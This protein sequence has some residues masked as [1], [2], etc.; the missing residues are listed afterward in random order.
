MLAL[1]IHLLFLVSMYGLPEIT[2]SA[3]LSLFLKKNTAIKI[4]LILKSINP[5]NILE[6]GNSDCKKKIGTKEEMENEVASI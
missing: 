5:F 2:T 4:R 1:D 6:V 3:F